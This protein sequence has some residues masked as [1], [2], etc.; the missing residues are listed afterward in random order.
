LLPELPLLELELELE[1]ELEREEACEEMEEESE[2]RTDE[3][4]EE[5]LDAAEL[6][7]DARLVPLAVNM[8]NEKGGNGIYHLLAW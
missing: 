8:T 2:E 7:E 3:A 6:R 1:R 5:A 4:E